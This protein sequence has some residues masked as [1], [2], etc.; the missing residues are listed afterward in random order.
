VSSVRERLASLRGSRLARVPRLRDETAPRLRDE[1]APRL[2]DETAPR[3][4]DETAPRL[5][6]EAAPRHRDEAAPRHAGE[7]PGVTWRTVV[8][9]AGR[10]HGG[11]RPAELAEAWERGRGDERGR[12]HLA[13][14]ARA[15]WPASV[16][17]SGLLLIDLETT[18]LSLGAGNV[19][20]LVGLA[21]LAADGAV[22]VEQ[23][24]LSRPTAEPVMLAR[25]AER[26]DACGALVSFNGRAFDV[27]LLEGRMVL[28]RRR[29]PRRP[30][31]DLLP[32]A[33]RLFGGGAPD[34]RL[35]SLERH[36]LGFER[37]DDVASADVPAAWR[38]HLASGRWEPVE[39]VLEHNAW[40]L[41]SLAALA[42][43]IVRLVVP[44][45]GGDECADPLALAELRLRAG[46]P[47][48]AWTA[49]RGRAGP[50]PDEPEPRRVRR[51]RLVKRLAGAER[52]HEHWRAL[53]AEG[54]ARP[55]AFE[56]LAK[57]LEHR[58]RDLAA[59]RA[60]VIEALACFRRRGTVRRRLEH[61]LGRLDRKLAGAP[62]TRCPRAGSGPSVP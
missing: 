4:R 46:E 10:R 40:D 43:R 20:W 60:V 28:A 53:V 42:A 38:E 57:V 36:V 41:L 61:R 51:A 59:A 7:G 8:L 19:P 23:G 25:V 35:I 48:E 11:V 13:A 24:V 34:A 18:G 12:R 16:P 15:G 22:V 1:T 52:A 27:P 6:D 47:V 55:E 17:A 45:A 33:R 9:E 39:R 26:V 62:E 30:H 58:D 56:E 31:L 14:L 54:C 50:R 29:L 32:P 5:R 21:R 37:P 3:L 2:R 44:G 49:L